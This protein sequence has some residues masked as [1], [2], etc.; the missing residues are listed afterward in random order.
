MCFQSHRWMLWRSDCRLSRRRSTKVGHVFFY[1]VRFFC[2]QQLLSHLLSE[3]F[4]SFTCSAFAC[5]FIALKCESAPWGGV[6]RPSKCEYLTRSRML[7]HANLLCV[8]TRLPT[9]HDKTLLQTSMW[10]VFNQFS[11][12]GFSSMSCLFVYETAITVSCC[13]QYVS[14]RNQKTSVPHLSELLLDS[15]SE[16]LKVSSTVVS[17]QTCRVIS[18]CLDVIW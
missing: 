9:T 10:F 1:G 16:R 18:H 17:K 4:L 2:F 12:S 7:T 6:S 11:R 13:L 8:T 14:S 15:F 3:L 5:F